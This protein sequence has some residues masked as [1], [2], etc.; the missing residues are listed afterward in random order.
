MN[1]PLLKIN[2]EDLEPDMRQ[3]LVVV[4]EHKCPD[5]G[6][7]ANRHNAVNKIGDDRYI[8]HCGGCGACWKSEGTG[9]ITAVYL[10]LSMRNK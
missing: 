9:F 1:V 8:A 7:T 3:E 6:C 4:E 5:C 2:A 10:S